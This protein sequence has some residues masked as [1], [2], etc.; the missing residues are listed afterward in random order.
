MGTDEGLEGPVA[1]I[2][3]AL[4]RFAAVTVLGEERATLSMSASAVQFLNLLQLHGSLTPGELARLSGLGTGT[5]TGVIDRLEEGGYVH[6][7]RDSR[8][9]R[10]VLVV[11]D[12]DRLVREIMP[13]YAGRARLLATLAA[14]YTDDQLQLVAEFLGRYVSDLES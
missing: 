13:Q 1:D 11:P 10:K 8:D 4:R 2:G 7:Q 9:R 3:A 5:V 14:D 12:H 6:R